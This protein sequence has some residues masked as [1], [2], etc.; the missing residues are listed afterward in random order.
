[1]YTDR[2]IYTT[3]ELLVTKSGKEV[4]K[5]VAGPVGITVMA[6]KSAKSGL[7]DYLMLFMS[8]NIMLAV[9]NLL[10]IPIL[11]GGYIMITCLET[12]IR[13]PVPRKLLEP[14]M[15][16]FFICF[17]ILFIFLFSN[18]LVRLMFKS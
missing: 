15:M 4:K 9:M 18:D 13:R 17:I 7:E 2:V 8:I 10:P 3:V 11:D 16:L 14:V 6:Y 1:V 5:N 12:L